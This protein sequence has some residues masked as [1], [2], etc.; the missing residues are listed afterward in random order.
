MYSEN[1]RRSTDVGWKKFLTVELMGATVAAVFV[2][3]GTFVTLSADVARAQ[4]STQ[5][6][7]IKLQNLAR[8]VASIDTDIRL[9]AADANH[10]KDTLDEVKEDIKEQRTDIKEILRILG[11]R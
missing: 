10:N 8:Q 4:V 5:E 6:N 1:R 11:S 7:T 2:A 3:G 9:I